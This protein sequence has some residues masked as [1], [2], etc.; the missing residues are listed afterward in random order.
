MDTD[1]EAESA[2]EAAGL[3][4]QLYWETAEYDAPE[5]AELTELEEE[6]RAYCAT[7]RRS[8]PDDTG[9][10]TLLAFL[11]F[12]KL[13]A[14]LDEPVDHC[15]HWRTDPVRLDDDDEPGRE[16]AAEAIRSARRALALRGSD[17][18]AAFSLACGLEW[19]GE[20][21]AAATAYL[22]AFRLDPQD[23]VAGARAEVLQEGLKVPCPV[24]G[25]RP[26]QP[27]G[28]HQLVRT[29]VVGHSGSTQGVECL[30]ADRAAIR[31]A[32]EAGLDDWLGDRG[33]VLDE[34]F[35][36]WTWLPGEAP[37]EAPGELTGVDLRKALTRT[38][39]GRQV[40]D[41]PAVPLPAL[42]RPLPAGLPV[43]WYGNW[44]FHGETEH[45]D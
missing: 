18:I 8:A 19:L 1:A 35:M 4:L 29:R 21:E 20:H 13:R 37:G 41:W 6:I 24:P 38:P 22:E 30:S 31:A 16:L 45:T 44:H 5:E 34:D 23:A 3:S 12:A 14:H 42:R 36:L 15:D 43:R 40:I 39:E 11:D 32:A 27:Y 28:F 9:P 2:R 17:N 10:A 7:V 33:P 26:L 25:R